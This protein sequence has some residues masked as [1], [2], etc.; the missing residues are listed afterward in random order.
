VRDIY[1]EGDYPKEVQVSSSN[2][3]DDILKL[4]ILATLALYDFNL[5]I[6][7]LTGRLA[8]DFFTA[9]LFFIGGAGSWSL[10]I[11]IAP[12]LD[13]ERAVK[14]LAF[15]GAMDV[16]GT[17][18]ASTM[19]SLLKSFWEQGLIESFKVV[20]SLAI[21][22]IGSSLMADDS[23]KNW[24]SSIAER[25]T[26][27]VISSAGEASGILIIQ[28]YIYLVTLWFIHSSQNYTLLFLPVIFAIFHVLL[29]YKYR[30]SKKSSK[31]GKLELLKQTLCLIFSLVFAPLA[32]I[33]TS[34]FLMGRVPF[35][36]PPELIYA[37][38]IGDLSIL[39]AGIIGIVFG[40]ML[41]ET[42]KKGLRKDLYTISGF[43][44]LTTAVMISP[45]SAYTLLC[46]FIVALVIRTL[47]YVNLK[48][49]FSKL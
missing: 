14:L 24:F 45:L 33:L 41:K 35:M 28:P 21:G 31:E 48:T 3:Q 15:I 27:G 46:V 26:R 39:I 1:E 34:L 43:I 7:A 16:V 25:F 13:T 5:I 9:G 42:W 38:L 32:L 2:S 8:T 19:I 10:A 20:G 49:L 18:Y 40:A 6:L 12:T 11:S 23:V 17:I 22:L 30:E 29:L 37:V 36:L 4:G 47:S 44:V